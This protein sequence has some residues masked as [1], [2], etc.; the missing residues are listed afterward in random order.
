[1]SSLVELNE[2][3]NIESTE[4]EPI[5][6]EALIGPGEPLHAP[7]ILTITI[8]NQSSLPKA[9]AEFDESGRMRDSALYRRVVDVYEK[10]VEFTWL[11][12]GRSGYLTQRY[13]ERIQNTE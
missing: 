8:P 13:S 9:F 4:L 3:P 5:D 12:R 1:M 11:T 7:R 2:L 10:L 6:I